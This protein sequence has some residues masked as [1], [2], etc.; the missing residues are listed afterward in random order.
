MGLIR[1]RRE[2]RP[3]TVQ[4][5]ICGTAFQTT[6]SQGKYCSPKCRRIGAKNSWNKN[7][8]HYRLKMCE[9]GKRWY[10]LNKIKRTAQINEYQKSKRGIE[11]QHK[12]SLNQRKNHPTECNARSHL[13]DA[14]RYGKITPIPCVICGNEVVEAHHID[15]NK[16]LNVVW[17]CRKH[18]REV[19]K[20]N[21]VIEDG[22][23]VE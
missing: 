11:V 15:Y 22:E 13:N 6:H 4:C 5:V 16:P 21:I 19:H 18:H 20:G 17:L 8:A 12:S 23:V 9:Y 14:K 1:N 2:A 7:S 3:R 10:E